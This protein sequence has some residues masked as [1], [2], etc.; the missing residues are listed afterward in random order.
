MKLKNTILFL[1]LIFSTPY[2]AQLSSVTFRSEEF[3]QFSASK[4]FFV[5][6]GDATF[7]SETENALRDLWKLTPFEVINFETFEEKISDAS[8]SFILSIIISG[9]HVEQN[10]HYLA[11]INGGK[12]SLKKYQYEDMIAYCPINHFQNEPKNTD[13]SYRVRNMVESMILTMEL[14]QKNNIRGNTFDVVKRLQE[15]YNSR[16]NKIKERTMLFCESSFGGKMTKA[17]IAGL[18]PFK[19]E[20]CD[21]EKIEQVI[22]DKSTDYYYFQPCFTLNKSVWVV[23]PSNGE[24]VYFNFGLGGFGYPKLKTSDIEDLTEAVQGKKK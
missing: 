21:K 18:Y 7:D 6:T 8:S 2:F 13:C 22:K 3:A 24:I 11:L 1:G 19:F 14:V 23:D 17:D 20:M 12:K 16:N 10:Y 5:K 9:N 15:I 4:T